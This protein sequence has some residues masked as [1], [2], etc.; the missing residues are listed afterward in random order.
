MK[1]LVTLAV[2]AITIQIAAAQAGIAHLNIRLS[3]NSPFRLLIDGY[4]AG[5]PGRTVQ[6][7]NLEPGRHYIQVMRAGNHWGNRNGSSVFRGTIV[8]TPNSESFVTVMPEYNKVRFD[9]IEAV[10][11]GSQWQNPNDPCFY[12]VQPTVGPGRPGYQP[13]PVVPVGPMSMHPSDFAQLKQTIN[14]AGFE[15]TRLSIFKQAL[16]FN[17][18]NTQQVRELMDL[19]W[20]ESSKLEVAK[21]AYPKT[22]DQQN[23]YL[24]NNGFSFSSSVN[25]LSSYIAMR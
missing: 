23:Y 8:L 24:V 13:A 4:E 7:H 6:V 2:L 1:R 18:F 9:R 5:A 19:F 11:P 3:D 20:F 17:H 22:V 21:L 25:Q 10:R 14:N 16:S 12:P 15:S